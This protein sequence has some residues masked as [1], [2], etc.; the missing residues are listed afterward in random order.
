MPVPD[1]PRDTGDRFTY[2]HVTQSPTSVQY[3][4][5]I[6]HADDKSFNFHLQPPVPMPAMVGI[7]WGQIYLS[8]RDTE[9]YI[10]TIQYY[11][12]SC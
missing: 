8:A 9:S 5:T 12:T 6:H 4:P 1:D 3:N 7:Y 10:R 11:N 2:Q